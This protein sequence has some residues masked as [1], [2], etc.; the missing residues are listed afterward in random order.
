MLALTTRASIIGGAICIALLLLLSALRPEKAAGSTQQMAARATNVETRTAG[1]LDRPAALFS[2]EGLLEFTLEADF[3][4]LKKDRGQESEY[5]P[6]RCAWV[7]SV[8][9]CRPSPGVSARR[10]SA[11]PRGCGR[12]RPRR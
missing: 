2:G 9:T 12:G 11:A 8:T 4:E 6:G 1:S 7:A 5:R 10:D 3:K